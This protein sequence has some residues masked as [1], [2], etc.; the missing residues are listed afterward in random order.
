MN[1]ARSMLSGK[2]PFRED[3]LCSHCIYYKLMKNT[4]NWL[5]PADIYFYKIGL[6]LKYECI[7]VFKG[8]PLPSK[9]SI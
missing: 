1:Y 4:E 3:I 9:Y 5:T 2:E 8:Y 7:R 6:W